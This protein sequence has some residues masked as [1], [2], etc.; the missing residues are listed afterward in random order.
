M[1]VL[2]TD[3][4]LEGP[5]IGQILAVLYREA[6]DIPVINLQADVPASDPLSSAYLLA[7]YIPSFPIGSVFLCIVDPGVGSARLPLAV[8]V[9]HMWFVAPDNGLLELVMRRATIV[10]PFAI[11]W[12]PSHLGASFHGRD[13]FAPIAAR[14][15][16]G[17]N[18]SCT[19]VS[20]RAISRPEWVDDL[21]S[22]VYIDKFGN[23]ITG[24]RATL[25]KAQTILGCGV[26]RVQWARTFYEVP[27]GTAFW[28]ENSNGLV[29]IAVNQGRASE[30]F[31]L[32]V[33]SRIVI[34]PAS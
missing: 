14:L 31:G 30:K 13:L 26:H 11:T 27:I 21:L 2:F 25:V 34:N 28:Y 23:S 19:S 4:G 22:I 15:A 16:R 3:L 29:E 9:D 7:A 32:R 6:P 24:L 10:N 33:G 1:I 12:E 18:V 8:R 5:Y 20:L 17:Q